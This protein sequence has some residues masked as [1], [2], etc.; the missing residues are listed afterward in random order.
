MAH[1]GFFDGIGHVLSGRGM[2]GGKFQLRLIFQPVL[3]LLLG[4]RFG[5][6]D[7]KAGKPAFLMSLV[8]AQHERWPILKQGLRDAIIPLCIALVIDGILQRMINGYV[9]PMA[10]I[11]VGVLL[12]FLPFVIGRGLSNRIWTTGHGRQIP[13][14]P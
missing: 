2:F 8:E 6:R 5:I 11:V 4:V 14:A 3:A 10:A 1:E 9:R 13:H 12:V 7:A